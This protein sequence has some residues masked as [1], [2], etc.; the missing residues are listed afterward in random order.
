MINN[1]N[2]IEYLYVGV[3]PKPFK[4][5]NYWYID[6]EKVSKP[7]TYV[8]GRM[9]SHNREQILYVDSVQLFTKDKAPYPVEKTR[10]V[11][12]QTTKEESL[13]ADENWFT[14]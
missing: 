7:N 3:S 8:W 11:I 1:D 10:R 12:R 5:L 6:E 9:G 14:L 13:E 4:G 2:K